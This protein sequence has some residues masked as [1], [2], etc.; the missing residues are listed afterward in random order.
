MVRIFKALYDICYHSLVVIVADCGAKGQ[1][2]NPAHLRT[3]FECCGCGKLF[4]LT[5]WNKCWPDDRMTERQCSTYRP[6]GSENLYELK[7]IIFI[8]EEAMCFPKIHCLWRIW[9][10]NMIVVINIIP[11]SLCWYSWWWC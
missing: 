1:W 2:F 8:P 3:E 11:E 5:Q 9:T 7:S 4:W 6:V 10:L